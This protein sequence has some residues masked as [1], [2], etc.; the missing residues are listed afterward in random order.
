MVFNELGRIFNLRIP[1]EGKVIEPCSRYDYL[2][3][4]FTPSGSFSLGRKTLY[5][6]ANGAMLSFLSEFN[7]RA[8]A[9]PSTI[10]NLFRALV[11]P[12]LLHNFEVWGSFLKSKSNTSFEKYQAILFDDKF[13]HELLYNRL[14]KHLL[15][16]H[17]KASSF[18]VKGELGC[19]PINI[20]LYTRLLKF[21]FHLLEISEGNPLIENSI[22]ACNILLEAG[23]TSWLSTISHLLQLIDLNLNQI[24]QSCCL[25]LKKIVH[26]VENELKQLYEERFLSEISKSSRLYYLY[27]LLKKKNTK[28]NYMLKTYFI[29]NIDHLWLD[30]EYLLTSFQLKLDE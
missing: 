11:K 7:L 16:V 18:A 4:T 28:W 24:F 6:M 8:G 9:Q 30:S 26:M 14:C 25:D 29:T 15:G 3:T 12:I 5:K 17:S 23:K 2:G 13:H 10:Q 21:L 22:K 27:R 20:C 1:F 19:Y